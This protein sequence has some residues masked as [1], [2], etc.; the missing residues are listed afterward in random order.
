MAWGRRCDPGCESWPDSDDYKR[1]PTCGEKTTRYSNLRPLDE[2]EAHSLK[3]QGEFKVFYEVW[4][5]KKGQSDDGPLPMDRE[6]A[7]YWDEKYPG[8][9]PDAPPAKE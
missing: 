8:G 5:R 2:G 1:C 6:E 7:V 3:A 9:R 4:C